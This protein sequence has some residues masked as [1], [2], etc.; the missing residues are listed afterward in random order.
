MSDAPEECSPPTSPRKGARTLVVLCAEEDPILRHDLALARLIV[1]ATAGE[2]RAIVL[3][4]QE[5][6]ALAQL[7]FAR[8]LHP[9]TRLRT[10]LR[11]QAI[12]A[13][14]RNRSE[15]IGATFHAA[16]AEFE[17][18]VEF[19]RQ[20]ASIAAFTQ[21]IFDDRYEFV[22]F[23][24]PRVARVAASRLIFASPRAGTSARNRRRRGRDEGPSS[25]RTRRSDRG[26][27]IQ[28][29]LLWCDCAASLRAFDLVGDLAQAGHQVHLRVICTAAQ[30]ETLEQTMA[31][32]IV[33]HADGGTGSANVDIVPNFE[34]K[35][36]AA[37][38]RATQCDIVVAPRI[39]PVFAQGNEHA[40]GETLHA[41]L[42]LVDAL[43]AGEQPDSLST[44]ST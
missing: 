39:H 29:V 28:I 34:R 27:Q 13:R 20:K 9:N 6:P 7:P 36:L 17:A 3:E 10:P 8:L 4:D 41:P 14:Q 32:N 26:E 33:G 16:L 38:L 35:H 25:D 2:L 30:L 21:R 43:E 18:Q 24:L 15:R 37:Y 22:L 11:P 12:A 31:H 40:F 5:L 23:S 1:L 44:D 42:L 19:E